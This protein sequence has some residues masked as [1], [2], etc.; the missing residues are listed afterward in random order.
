MSLSIVVPVYNESENINSFIDRI[1]LILTKINAKYEIIFVLDPS[2]DD[3]ENKILESIKKN[4]NIQRNIL[5]ILL[6]R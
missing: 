4:Q 5:K 1:L 2:E 6:L 3:S